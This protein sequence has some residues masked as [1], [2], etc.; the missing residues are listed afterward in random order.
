MTALQIF[1]HILQR[2]FSGLY[3]PLSRKFTEWCYGPVR[4]SLYDLS[5]VDSWEKNSVLEIIAFHCRSPVSPWAAGLPRDSGKGQTFLHFIVQA[6]ARGREAPSRGSG[7]GNLFRICSSPSPLALVW[8]LPR[9]GCCVL[10]T[11]CFDSPFPAPA[12]APHGGFRATEQASA[13]EMGSA[14]PQILLQLR[15]LPGLHAGL[16]HCC[17]PPAFP[18]EGK[19]WVG[20]SRAHLLEATLEW[21][22]AGST[23]PSYQ[24]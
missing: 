10:P 23:I 15:L 9:S 2:E 24:R 22:G 1:R 11:L 8:S 16:H 18:G 3:Q 21:E 7:S 13:G 14:H 5:S 20:S 12:P 4:V 19:S 6:E 17:L